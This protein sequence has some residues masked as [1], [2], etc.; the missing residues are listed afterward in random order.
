MMFDPV[1]IA[2]IFVCLMLGG[3]VKGATGAGAPLFAVPA[4]TALFDVRFAIIIMIVPNILTNVW[5]SWTFRENTREQGFLLPFL[6]AAVVGMMVG[7]WALAVVSDRLLAGLL[8]LALVAYLILRFAK[9]DW[10]ITPEQGRATALPAG[11]VS[12]ALQGA[13]GLSAPASLTYLS[14]MRLPRPAFAGA[15]SQLFVLLAAVQLPALWIAGLIDLEGLALS[16]LA[17]LPVV[18][19]M[20][21]G[22]WLIK[23]VSPARFQFLLLVLLTGLA[24]TLATKAIGLT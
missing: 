16:T 24:V 21:I 20:P 23:Y 12:G 9:P 2:I 3:V 4:M 5:Q 13:S 18:A 8:C 15:I 22:N 1:A 7:T 17:I 11:L 19:G 14:A 10:S 6:A